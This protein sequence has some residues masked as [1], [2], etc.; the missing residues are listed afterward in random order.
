MQRKKYDYYSS[1]D[2]SPH[3]VVNNGPAVK[4]YMLLSF[5]LT[6]PLPIIALLPPPSTRPGVR[7][8]LMSSLFPARAKIIPHLFPAPHFHSLHSGGICVGWSSSQRI[9]CLLG[10]SCSSLNPFGTI[11]LQ[12]NV[13]TSIFPLV[14]ARA[15]RAIAQEYSRDTPIAPRPPPLDASDRLPSRLHLKRAISSQYSNP[16]VSTSAYEYSTQRLSLI[17]LVLLEKR[18]SLSS[19]MLFVLVDLISGTAKSTYSQCF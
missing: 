1:L 12:S 19:A 13:R 5:F 7:F 8:S 6:V 14:S 16:F 11:L 18:V 2:R 10:S 15:D 9:L 4:C 3:R 17:I